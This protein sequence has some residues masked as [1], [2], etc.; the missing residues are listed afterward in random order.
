MV[1]WFVFVFLLL[2]AALA[3]GQTGS[4]DYVGTKDVI[5][6]LC[7]YLQVVSFKHL[8]T[9]NGTRR[10][11]FIL[12]N[13]GD[14]PIS[15][16]RLDV[17]RWDAF[18]EVLPGAYRTGQRGHLVVPLGVGE[19]FED[20]FEDGNPIYILPWTRL[21]Y[22]TRVRLDDGTVWKADPD[23]L[24]RG[25]RKQVPFATLAAFLFKDIH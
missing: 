15:A 20:L 7:P 24:V 14:K 1:K 4:V 12:K 22:V 8:I 23:E 25:A 16:L 13:V 18:N 5:V 21:C 9:G 6:N 10:E 17:A 19:T 2:S 3:F 11:E